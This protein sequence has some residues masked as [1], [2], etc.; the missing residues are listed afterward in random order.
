M[1]NVTMIHITCSLDSKYTRFAGVL[2]TS[3]FENNKNEKIMM[4]IMGFKLSDND[5]TDL[6]YIA[7]KYKNEITF[8]DIDEKEFKDFKTTKQWNIATYFRLLLPELID[9]NVERV[10]YVD[11]DIIFRGKIRE[12]YDTDLGDNI[13][14]A[15]EDHVLSPRISLNYNHGIH[16][17]SFYFNAGVILIDL[18]K[19]REQMITKKCFEY[20]HK[21]EPMH[22]D[23]DTLNAVLQGKW[24]H[25]SYRY[26]FMSDFHSAYFSKKDFEMDMHKEYPYYPIIIHFTGIKP[27]NHASRSAYK[28][29]FFKY[30][31][32]TKWRN[33]I[34]KHTL[35]EKIINIIREFCDKT[36]IKKKVPFKRYDF[37][38]NKNDF[39]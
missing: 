27:W 24:K 22:L 15:V 18:Q 10:L 25:L 37:N 11:C 39:S 14:G 33:M 20:L 31:S 23:Q 34:P 8:Y 3:I 5:K 38:F 16:P 28:V 19:W 9:I 32:M 13:I 26:N 7:E 30:Q 12:L 17:E 29:D 1:E 35:K 6:K 4:H 36:G 2:M 21:H